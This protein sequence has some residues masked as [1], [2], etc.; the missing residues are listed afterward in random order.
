M[1]TI[2]LGGNEPATPD[3][4]STGVLEIPVGQE[5]V[6]GVTIHLSPGGQITTKLTIDGKTHE[7]WMRARLEGLA[8]AIPAGRMPIA[9]EAPTPVTLIPEGGV[10]YGGTPQAAGNA[11]S[12]DTQ[13]VSPGRYFVNV[14]GAN[15]GFYVK[16][17]KLNGID[18]PRKPLEFR[19]GTAEL[20]IVAATDFGAVSGAVTGRGGTGVPR[21]L[22]SLWPVS[23]DLSR[24]DGGT[25]V[26]VASD[27]ASFM[28]LN[29]APGEYYAAAFEDLP[30]AGL[31]RYL[32]FLQQF[33][34]RAK[35]VTVAPKGTASA[36]LEVIPL[37][38]MQR[39][40]S[41]LR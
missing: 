35:R 13:T 14:S 12:K 27:N 37:N 10:A 8:A 41:N 23:P 4:G 40:L 18:I 9:V 38:E 30:D 39:V 20:E 15:L 2:G 11:S 6:E 16:S 28:A 1:K 7:E 24:Q 32:P 34:A 17:M 26:A 22:V 19:G 3:D 5:D 29:V 36:N 31:M 21:A 33:T 25:F